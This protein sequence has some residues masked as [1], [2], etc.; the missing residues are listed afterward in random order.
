MSVERR[1][2]TRFDAPEVSDPRREHLQ[3]LCRAITAYPKLAAGVVERYGVAVVN[4]TYLSAAGGPVLAQDI[5]CDRFG[6]TWWFVWANDGARI[7]PVSELEAAVR[8]IAY[9]MGA[10]S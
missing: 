2:R 9:E 5:G 4:V 6:D 3:E 1:R 7:A 10:D 8:E